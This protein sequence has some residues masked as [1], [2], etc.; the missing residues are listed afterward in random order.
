MKK[1]YPLLL[2]SIL[3]FW[4][5]EEEIEEEQNQEEVATPL[6]FSKIFDGDHQDRGQSV[7]QT[8]D[9]GYIITGS[10]D[11]HGGNE[12]IWLI[13]TD[14]LGNEE[15]DKTFVEGR[16]YSV[17]QTTDGGYIIT[18]AGFP[19]IYG[20]I[21]LIKTDSQ[22]N[23]EWIKE[24]T[25]GIGFSVQQTTD[26][27]YI[28][29]GYTFATDDREDICLI[30]TD[31]QGNEEWIQIFGGEG[32]SDMGYSVQ[33]TTDGGYII[34]GF[35]QASAGVGQI[36]IFLRKT[37]PQGNEEWIQTFGGEGVNE[38]GQSVQQ[39]TDGGY[40]ITGNYRTEYDF[41]AICLIKTNSEGNEEW[42]QTFGGDKDEYGY[43]VQQTT[44]GGYITTG[45]T[46]SFGMNTDDLQ[47]NGD[48]WLI[49][50]DSQGMEEWNQTFG[51]E[52][53]DC[54]KSVQQTTDGGYIIV[55]TTASFGI[56]SDPY[57]VLLIK[58]DSEGNSVP[59]DD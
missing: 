28:I 21:S 24:Y 50:T 33:Q 46:K 31:S 30:K 43:S 48:V 8:T 42:I 57:R 23:E 4:V 9:G 53:W 27:G 58:T 7:Q 1:L 15:W 55:G 25:S 41:S 35:S 10:G 14:S 26:G 6:V 47:N 11:D 3:I 45:V 29:T 37:D 56:N 36:I 44:D 17:Q 12:T 32:L 13:K 19:I 51:G 40:I 2:I 49:K 5:C 18:G 39:T 54:G 38:Y 22:G 52:R 59:F 34:T 16:G 20:N